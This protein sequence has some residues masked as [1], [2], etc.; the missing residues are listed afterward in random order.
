MYIIVGLGNPG[1]KYENTRQYMGFLT[2]D[3]IAEKLGIKVEVAPGEKCERCWM[4][5][6][7]VGCDEKHPTLCHRC[8]DVMKKL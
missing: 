3:V 8:A 6:E 7:E 1:K 4:Y 5:S 2:I